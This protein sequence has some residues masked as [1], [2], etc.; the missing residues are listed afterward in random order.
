MVVVVLGMALMAVALGMFDYM[1]EAMRS[2]LGMRPEDAS[3]A[4]VLPE[5]GC[6]LVVFIAGAL[7]G[8]WGRRRVLVGGALLFAAGG[9][10][11]AA[12][13][14]L[15][16]LVVGRAFEGIG[17]T[18]TAIVALA[19]LSDAFPSGRARALAFGVSAAVVPAVWVVAP[20]VG[21]WVTLAGHWRL[22]ALVWVAAG[23]VTALA[24]LIL[25]PRDPAR[26]HA[27]LV[28]PLLAGVVLAGVVAAVT[29]LVIGGRPV[30]VGGIIATV[31]GIV[32]LT[33]AMRRT[34]APGLDLRLPFSRPGALA[35]GAILVASIV[36]L[37]FFT[38]LLLQYRY[39]ASPMDIA[40]LLLPLQ[41]AATAGGLAG[42]PV[43]A[44]IGVVRAGT[45]L[46]LLGAAASLLALLIDPASATWMPVL[47]ICLFA[48]LDAATSGPLTARVMDLAPRGG[49]GA[50]SAHRKAAGSIGTAIG[51]VVASL[52]VLT[53]FQ[54]TLQ[55]E[56]TARGVPQALASDV[57]AR[58]A[59][60][61]KAAEVA[62]TID[63]PPAGVRDLL[64][65]DPQPLSAAQVSTY[66]DVAILNAITYVLA[67]AMFMASGGALLRGRRRRRPPSH[68][69][70]GG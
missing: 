56:L 58:V 9:V 5:I 36:N 69:S 63:A 30:L 40:L 54:A 25:M 53:S 24:A 12:T 64:G 23:L 41:V 43:M 61:T 68:A 26:R 17:G 38:S 46:L 35:L 45:L 4:L 21:A 7:G 31:A 6:L 39:D 60:G 59:D 70:P 47:T 33:V 15:A 44:R 67:A 37:I 48:G 49:D 66:H 16:G 42:G 11:I 14:S 18:V 10:M 55:D 1:V 34:R 3:V 50:A 27:E 62:G 32:A 57:A 8:A 22:A 51:G 52:L 65:P 20:F 13:P 19:M 28:T 2:D 29:S